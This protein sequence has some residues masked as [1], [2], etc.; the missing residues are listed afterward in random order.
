[1]NRRTRKSASSVSS[2][3]VAG[4]PRSLPWNAAASSGREFPNHPRVGVGG[5][6]VNNGRVLLVRRGQQP[7]KGKW[8][9]PGGLVEV[10]ENLTQAL[11]REL[12]EE[13]GLEVEPLQVIGVFERILLSQRSS[14]RLRRVRYH[15]VLIDYACRL[16]RRRQAQR[17][18]PATD[19]T[20]ACWVRPER[21]A[22]FQLTAQA[23]G[24]IFEALRLFSSLEWS[25]L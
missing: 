23:R 7:L 22:Q 21:L 17:L 10:G 12:K 25:R 15:Y 3:R 19:V 13:T 6:V 5:V 11:R 20:A 14:R 8:S 9:L 18:R 24:V 16:R 2:G 4:S 1:M